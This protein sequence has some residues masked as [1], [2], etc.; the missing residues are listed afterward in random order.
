MAKSKLTIDD[1]A[2]YFLNRD[3][4]K[5]EPPKPSDDEPTYADYEAH[6]RGKKPFSTETLKR[7]NLN[8]AWQRKLRL[9][10][11]HAGTPF[12]EPFLTETLEYV[13]ALMR[14][15]SLEAAAFLLGDTQKDEPPQYAAVVLDEDGRRLG[16][17][18]VAIVQGPRLVDGELT[19]RIRI[20]SPELQEEFWPIPLTIAWA[21]PATEICELELPSAEELLKIRVP[22]DF[23]DERIRQDIARGALPFGFVIQRR[24]AQAL[25]AA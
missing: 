13:K 24:L 5:P 17:G 25:L 8:P 16:D 18:M 20:V 19:M 1:V 6:V 10:R 22:A 21:S 3:E 14:N 11:K 4:I 15:G 2:E 9:F 23:T 12:W 7:I